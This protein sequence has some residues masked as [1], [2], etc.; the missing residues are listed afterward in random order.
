M[1]PASVQSPR[2]PGVHLLTIVGLRSTGLPTP[3]IDRNH[4][5]CNTEVL[6]TKTMVFFGVVSSVTIESINRQVPD[7][8]GDGRYEPRGIIAGPQAHLG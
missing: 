3:R 4:S 8:L 2:E 6:T 1:P 7:R 5:G